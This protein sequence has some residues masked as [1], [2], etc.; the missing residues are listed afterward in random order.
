MLSKLMVSVFGMA[1]AVSAAAQERTPAVESAMKLEAEL[2]TLQT[3]IES[4]TTE[5]QKKRKLEAEMLAAKMR[6][7][8]EASVVTG[9]PYSAEVVSESVQVLGDGNRIIRRTTGRVY[10]DSQGRIRRE[11]DREPGHVGS[12]SITDPVA[13]V[14]YSLD[15]ESKA[16]W[17]T[18]GS[19]ARELVRKIAVARTDPAE[20]ELRKKLEA[21]MIA[22]AS[23]APPKVPS[24]RAP[25]PA[26][27]E[28][29]E[30][31]PSRNIEGVMAQGTRTTRTIPAGAIGN[32]QPILNVTEEW[33]STEL[34]VLVMTRTSDPR[35]GES[36]YRLVNIVRA[37]PG[38]SWFELPADYTVQESPLRKREPAKQ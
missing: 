3:K 8:L 7:P 22:R 21:E 1:M 34:Q 24:L 17:R 10:R 12:I 36:T 32:E 38:Q 11:E 20:V 4:G 26:W 27:E 19:P 9:A 15:P 30:K 5:I 37:E 31:L 29:S 28:K 2:A 18:E 13:K 14:A 33:R 23:G 25:S 16:A 6:V 35:S